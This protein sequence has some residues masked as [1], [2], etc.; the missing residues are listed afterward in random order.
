LSLYLLSQLD[1]D[2]YLSLDDCKLYEPYQHVNLKVAVSDERLTDFITWDLE[3]EH[4]DLGLNSSARKPPLSHLGEQIMLNQ[5]SRPI[6]A[7]IDDIVERSYNNIGIAK[8]RLD[9]IHEMESLESLDAKKDQL[10]TS[11]TALFDFGLQQIE[12]LPARQRD[13]ALKSIAAAGRGVE[14][15]Q[16]PGL[17]ALLDFLGVDGVRSGEEIVEAAR[18]WLHVSSKGDPQS[19]L[20]YNMNFMYYV[21]Q[22]YHKG[23]HRSSVQIDSHEVQRRAALYDA[24]D[25]D[26][27]NAVRFEPQTM[28]ET[29]AAVTTYKLTRTVTAMPAIEEA[30][31]QPFLVRKG[32]IV[33]D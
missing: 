9:M 25:N 3:R 15:F 33:W 28:S 10:P 4:G 17:R 7:V 26:R 14:G 5:A 30:P 29:P 8:A 27:P 24:E 19:L 1:T 21:Q 6:Q 13:M 22:R 12:A 32:T 11:V 31:A 23:L 2:Q 18:G 20:V 16:I